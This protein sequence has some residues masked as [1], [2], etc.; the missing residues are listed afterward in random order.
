MKKKIIF[1]ISFLFFC[2]SGVFAQ[3]DTSCLGNQ[4]RKPVFGKKMIT[5][6][7]TSILLMDTC[8]YGNRSF[9]FN[10]FND[11]SDPENLS[12]MPAIIIDTA[13]FSKVEKF[14]DVFLLSSKKLKED[15]Y[16][17]YRKGVKLLIG[18]LDKKTA[19]IYITIQ[20]LTTEEYK[21]RD[22]YAHGMF[23]V[24]GQE[25]LKFLVLSYH[26]D[27]FKLDRSYSYHYRL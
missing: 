21:S 15:F 1:I 7:G 6:N 9:R 17:V 18:S 16:Q 13:M 10:I 3:N 20:L 19:S 8:D 2:H 22:Y 25:N 14:L 4:D 27:Q 5:Q 23:L 12:L 11:Q 24:T 26:D